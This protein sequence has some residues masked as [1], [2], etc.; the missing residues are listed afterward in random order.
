MSSSVGSQSEEQIKK[1]LF[2]SFP[3]SLLTRDHPQ[4]PSLISILRIYG[5]S[6]SAED[7]FYKTEAVLLSD[8]TDSITSNVVE[9]VKNG[10]KR[11]FEAKVKGKDHAPL[12]T[13]A[14]KQHRPGVASM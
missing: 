13:P 11:E 2:K 9:Q 8:N 12:S 10:L 14:P 4:L 6:V 1:S 7:L 5:S 3:Q